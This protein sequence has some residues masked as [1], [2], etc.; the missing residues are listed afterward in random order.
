MYSL[1]HLRCLAFK[2]HKIIGQRSFQICTGSQNLKLVKD[3]FWYYCYNYNQL[4][5]RKM[6]HKVLQQSSSNFENGHDITRV[7]GS[8]ECRCRSVLFNMEFRNPDQ[9]GYWTCVMLL[10]KFHAIPAC[11]FSSKKQPYHAQT[12][13]QTKSFLILF[14]NSSEKTRV[15]PVSVLKIDL[16]SV[17]VTF[18]G[19][20]SLLTAAHN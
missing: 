8:Q 3:K 15:S 19:F 13:V 17:T 10:S 9:C 4:K 16:N 7:L 1:I 6:D 5:S 14:P 20:K 12:L 18:I 11:I 2:L